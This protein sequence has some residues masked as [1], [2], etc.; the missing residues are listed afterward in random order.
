MAPRAY[1]VSYT[2]GSDIIEV[3]YE[4]ETNGLLISN[5]SYGIP[6]QKGGIL[7]ASAWRMGNYDTQA[8]FWDDLHFTFPYYLQVVSAGNDGDFS[9]PEASYDGYDKLTGEKNSKNNLVVANAQDPGISSTGELL[10]LNINSSSSQGP[11]D[12][13]CK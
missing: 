5:H 6:V 11:T 9:Y 10:S 12:T 8:Y 13:T 1:V 3:E 2:W 7:Y 4:I